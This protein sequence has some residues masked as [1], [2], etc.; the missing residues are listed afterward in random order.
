MSHGHFY[1]ATGQLVNGLR[2]ARTINPPPLPSPTTVLSLIKGEG[3]IYYWRKQMWES[4]RTTPRQPHWTDEEDFKAC[5]RW[6]DEH[7][8]GAR[9]KGGD[10]HDEIERFNKSGWRNL[11]ASEQALSYY[12]WHDQY[13]AKSIAVEQIV[14]GN[15]YAGRMDHLALLRDGR[16]AVVDVKSQD[17]SKRSGKFNHYPEWAL[18][19]GAY[20]A[21]A[22]PVPDV[23]VSVC[24]SSNT[25][26]VLEAYY[27][28]GPPSYYANLFIGLLMVWKEFNSYGNEISPP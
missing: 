4:A 21:A 22:K 13:V 6:A 26:V 16:V 8:K 9:D 2:E 7:G 27:W 3:L 20:A 17:V 23:L 28:P 18:Q 11:A 5:L 12:D 10:F 15:G 1:T 19:L 25:P 24:I 14:F